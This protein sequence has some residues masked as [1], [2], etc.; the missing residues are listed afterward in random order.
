MHSR[1]TSVLCTF[2]KRTL[3]CSK[4]RSDIA[5]PSPSLQVGFEVSMYKQSLQT[6]SHRS[7]SRLASPPTH[8]KP[9]L[10]KARSLVCIITLVRITHKTSVIFPETSIRTES[11]GHTPNRRYETSRDDTGLALTV[12]LQGLGGTAGRGRKQTGCFN[13]ILPSAVQ[14]YASTP[15]CVLG[16]ERCYWSVRASI[17]LCSARSFMKVKHTLPTVFLL[18]PL[19]HGNV[20]QGRS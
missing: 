19:K 4:S 15:D 12:G 7:S 16:E 17:T 3:T 2:Q 1:P 6:R 13:L 20:A 8:P 18:W 14:I 10:T 5:Q 9:P 11:E